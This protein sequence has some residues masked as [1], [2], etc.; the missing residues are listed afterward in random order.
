MIQ[1]KSDTI[2]TPEESVA[3][4]KRMLRLYRGEF[5]EEE[6]EIFSRLKREGKMMDK[7]IRAKNDGKNPILGY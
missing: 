3:F 1:M 5:T 2:M 4:R 7:L 6:R